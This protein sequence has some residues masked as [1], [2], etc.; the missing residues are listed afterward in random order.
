MNDAQFHAEFGSQSIGRVSPQFLKRWIWFSIRTKDEFDHFAVQQSLVHVDVAHV[1]VACSES[2]PTD[3]DDSRMPAVR[4]SM[5][6]VA[7]LLICPTQFHEPR[8]SI[9][10]SFIFYVTL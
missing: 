2:N 9:T 5:E 3:R 10:L 6:P 8:M 1:H 4:V 7:D